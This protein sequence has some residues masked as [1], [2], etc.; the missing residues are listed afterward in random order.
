MTSAEGWS[1]CN[2]DALIFH[3][4]I[5]GDAH[6]RKRLSSGMNFSAEVLIMHDS[7]GGGGNK[8]TILT[9]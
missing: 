9:H 3:E 4:E 7:G 1:F 2:C 6:M 5:L 8:N